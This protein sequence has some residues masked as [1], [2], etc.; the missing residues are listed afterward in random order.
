MPDSRGTTFRV[1][2]PRA[3]RVWLSLE[4]P[5]ERGLPMRREGTG[6]FVVRVNGIGAGARYRF[7]VDGAGPF[8][9]PAS[10]HQPDGV[11]G[12]SAVIDPWAFEWHDE[13]WAGVP[14]ERLVLYE[15]HVGTFTPDGTF[16][17]AIHRLPWLAS[18]G[19]TA[20]EL[21]PLSDFPGRRN[22]GYDGAA[23]FAPARA[24]GT[25]D[26]L[27]RLVD[28]AHAAGLAVHLD[29]VYNHFG[30]DGAYAGVFNPFMYSERHRSPWGAGI[31]LD[32]PGAETV[33][34]FFIENARHWIHEYHLDGLRLD[35]THALADE[36]PEPFVAELVARVRADAHRRP[37]VVI[38]EDSR[39]LAVMIERRSAGGWDLDAVWADDLHHQTRRLLA[40]DR[41][42][43]YEDFQG[44]TEDLATTI[45]Q[46]WFFT[47]Q[48]APHFGGPRGTPTG[49]LPR[50]RFVVCIQNHDQIG[51]RAFGERLHHQIP[52]AAY[53]AASVMLL[54][55]PETPLLFM[56]QE[57]A[58]TSPFLYFTDHHE[59]LGR[60]VTEGRRLEFRAFAAFTE[61]AGRARIPDP[62]AED[63]F[64]ASRLRWEEWLVEPHASVRRLYQMTLALRARLLDEGARVRSGAPDADTV[65][66]ARRSQDEELLVVVRLRGA[67]R[68]DLAPWLGQDGLLAVDSCVRL[69]TEWPTVAPDPAPPQV[70]ATAV[71]FLRPGA[72]VLAVAG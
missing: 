26:D 34:A 23:P 30:P 38:A 70:E 55:A 14:L 59:E 71:T 16:A 1:Q 25:P 52:L 40:G 12:T 21:M 29:V 15:L 28:A 46:G 33:R 17:A 19:V 7:L 45:R 44:T 22:W 69:S 11:H 66:I 37:V 42:G 64:T 39:N 62:Q 27:R 57:W 32:G 18:L 10:R 61:P 68:V 20:V 58:A 3:D 53:R 54:L 50:R 9:D 13:G 2:A 49:D 47:G 36:S 31:N 24:Y 63:T 43:Y 56:G 6:E 41:D 65:V 67:G 4:S 8:P 5:V 72:I 60:L 48:H 51:N 35:A